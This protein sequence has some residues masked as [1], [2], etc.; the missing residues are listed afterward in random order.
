MNGSAKLPT[1]KTPGPSFGAAPADAGISSHFSL[2]TCHD[3]TLLILI[4]RSANFLVQI[5]ERSFFVKD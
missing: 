1:R 2:T 4:W 3:H 5:T